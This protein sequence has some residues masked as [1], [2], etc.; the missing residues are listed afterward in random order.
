M[1]RER[2][3]REAERPQP[4][5]GKQTDAELLDPYRA[6]GDAVP[7]RGRPVKIVR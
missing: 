3:R 5:L 7:P 6:Y 1:T 2:A 4:A